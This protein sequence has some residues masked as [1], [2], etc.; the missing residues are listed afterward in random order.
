MYADDYMGEDAYSS[1]DV[2]SEYSSSV[3]SIIK[4]KHKI[5]KMYKKSDPDYYTFKHIIDGKIKKVELYSTPSGRNAF[6]RHAISGSKCPHR[7]GCREEDLYFKVCDTL[8][9]CNYA[10][11]PRQLYYY[12][13]EEYERH[14]NI[15][16]STSIKEDWQV[17]N[18]LANRLYN[19]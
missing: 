15:V 9:K 17:K 5:L 16:V 1:S 19:R 8:E 18:M 7:T 14:N 10:Y 3:D 4:E 12:N 2:T 11:G 6:I 13:P